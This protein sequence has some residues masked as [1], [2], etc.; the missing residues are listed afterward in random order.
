MFGRFEHLA[1]TAQPSLASLDFVHTVCS[2]AKYYYASEEKD[3]QQ[4]MRNIWKHVLSHLGG[5]SRPS[6]GRNSTPD[7]ALS[8]SVF[9]VDMPFAKRVIR[10]RP[11]MF[12]H[13]MLC[14]W[15]PCNPAVYFA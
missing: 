15:I 8:V 2:Q 5:V 10:A 1:E 13:A 9:N 4:V 11:V 12:H 3:Y 7:L 14:R 6:V